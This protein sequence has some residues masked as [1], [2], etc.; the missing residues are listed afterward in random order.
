MQIQI[1]RAL[2]Q[3]VKEMAMKKEIT[4]Q[5]FAEKALIEYIEKVKKDGK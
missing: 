5:H 4:I 2:H 1:D 3:K